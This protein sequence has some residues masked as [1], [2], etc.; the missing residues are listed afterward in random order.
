M[1]GRIARFD[2]SNIPPRE[3][4]QPGTDAPWTLCTNVLGGTRE[5]AKSKA[6]LTWLLARKPAKWPHTPVRT[7]L[8][9]MKPNSLSPPASGSHR[10]NPFVLGGTWC[11]SIR[12]EGKPDRIEDGG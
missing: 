3:R 4:P 9:P 2:P 5:L 1:S 12:T 7:P 6:E 8:K 10:H 11:F